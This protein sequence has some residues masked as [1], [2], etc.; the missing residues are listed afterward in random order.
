M[1]YQDFNGLSISR[2]G[3]GALRFP[4]LPGEPN[5]IDTVQA[6]RIV[7]E[8]IAQGINYFDTAYTYQQGDSE[9]ALGE[10]LSHHPRDSFFLATKFYAAAKKDIASVFEEQL[11]RLKTDY[12]DFYLL[13]SLDE[14]YIQD[15]T[16]P[17]KDYLGFLLRQKEAG[18][19]R[20]I[21]FSSHGSPETL[22]KFLNWY[23]G[24]DMALIQLN[25]LD[26]TLLDG[27]GQ[28]DILTKHHIPI[29]VMEPLKGG[30]LSTLNQES[31]DILQKAAPDWSIS[32]WG[33]RFLMELPGV[34]T[35]L[36]GMSTPEQVRENA[37][38]FSQARPFTQ[39]E[40]QALS[41]AA[42]V[43]LKDL[44]VPCSGCRY[45]CDT[46][47]AHLNIPLLIQAY[48]EHRISGS[49]WKIQ[50]LTPTDRAGRCLHCGAC[51]KHCPQKIQIPTIMEEAAKAGL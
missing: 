13:H 16:D 40:R 30:R 37:A 7:D 15:Y 2:L 44:G 46:C 5:H 48:N 35:V 4:T 26:W 42:E 10:A 31:Q 45:C 1:I 3:L 29:W 47:P 17:Q 12:F 9:R 51:L 21:G 38:T 20:H 39:E 34:Q 43:F 36:S 33:F 8:A 23:D 27:K 14:N 50:G 32:S 25:Y 24:F 22:E 11:R 6:R 49:T 19:I 41:Q 28:Y 18:K